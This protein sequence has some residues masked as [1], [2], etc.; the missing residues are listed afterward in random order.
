MHEAPHSRNA[1]SRAHT[2][3]THQSEDSGDPF[4]MG[5]LASGLPAYPVSYHPSTRSS[6]SHR[7]SNPHS[8]P[9]T[10]P[11]GTPYGIYPSPMAIVHVPMAFPMYQ[12]QHHA[13]TQDSMA[14]HA[15]ANDP[16]RTRSL[17]HAS[18]STRSSSSKN[19][20]FKS[21]PADGPLL[22]QTNQ[23]SS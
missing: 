7:S 18:E 11:Q 6:V 17:S 15:E 8:P 4:S 2:M 12:Q 20:H 9:L 3:P 10:S 5:A 23:T 22:P 14:H 16:G 21:T 19:S 1:S 13:L